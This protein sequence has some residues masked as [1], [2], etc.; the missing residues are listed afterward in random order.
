MDAEDLVDPEDPEDLVDP[1]RCPDADSVVVEE[2]VDVEVKM[3]KIEKCPKLRV[4]V[5]N[6]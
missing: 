2:A 6:P 4:K 1:E 3:D 5:N